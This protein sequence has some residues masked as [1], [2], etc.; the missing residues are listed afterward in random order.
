ML[1]LGRLTQLFISTSR[2]TPSGHGHGH[3]DGESTLKRN[4]WGNP[5]QAQAYVCC[6][7]RHLHVVCLFV[8]LNG[9]PYGTRLD[10][11]G[12]D[13]RKSLSQAKKPIKSVLVM[14]FGQSK[15]RLK[16]RT[17]QD[18][19]PNNQM[20]NIILLSAFLVE[21][22]EEKSCSN[23]TQQNKYCPCSSCTSFQENQ[24][25]CMI[26]R[27]ILGPIAI[28]RH[29]SKKMPGGGRPPPLKL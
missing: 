18:A 17:R 27:T 24:F 3:H 20:N 2:I 15:N 11:G 21:M 8:C 1:C 23:P 29:Y 12:L 25:S 16:K 9:R 22:R 10:P 4:R 19:T 5:L 7:K 6:R 13:S 26:E 28:S 14:K